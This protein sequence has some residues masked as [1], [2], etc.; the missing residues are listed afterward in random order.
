MA[1]Y[2][3]AVSYDPTLKASCVQHLAVMLV[4]DTWAAEV[5]FFLL[6]YS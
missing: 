4:L 6:P 2:M 3:H 5:L 1:S